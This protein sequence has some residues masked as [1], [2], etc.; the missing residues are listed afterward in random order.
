MAGPAKKARPIIAE[1]SGNLRS[2]ATRAQEP[3]SSQQP[4]SNQ[5][6]QPQQLGEKPL[7][8]CESRHGIRPCRRHEFDVEGRG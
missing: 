6:Q 5:P 1:L 7:S 3:A 2:L 4:A 8:P